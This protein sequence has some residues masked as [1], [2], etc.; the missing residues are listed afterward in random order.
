M[1]QYKWNLFIS[2]ASEDKDTIARPVANRLAEHGLK[3]WFDEAELQLGDSLRKKIDDGL[4]NSHAG[5]VILSDNFF[6]KHWPQTELD[7]VVSLIEQSDRHIFPVWHNLTPE[8]IRNYSPILS[9]M[10]AISTSVGPKEVAD[11]I[12]ESYFIKTKSKRR[13]QPIFAGR[14]TMKMLKKLPVGSVLSS[15]ICNPID[16]TPAFTVEIGEES[17]RALLWQQLKNESINKSKVYVFA[18]WAGYREHMANRHIW[19]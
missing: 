1:N 5:V 3:V 12:K 11:K 16:P 4:S 7:S 8:K 17:T 9:S 2:H 19:G 14:I 15:N 18:S 10:L 6:N 13:D